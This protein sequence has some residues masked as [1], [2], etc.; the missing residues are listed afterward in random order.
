MPDSSIIRRGLLSKDL[1]SSRF[2]EGFTIIIPAVV[3]KECDVGGGKKEFERLAEFASKGRIKL[4]TIGSIEEIPNT[5]SSAERDERIVSSALEYNA[6]VITADDSMK[7][8][9]ISKGVFTIF[10]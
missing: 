10:I 6:I 2:F 1:E 4:E 9:S 3:R 5:L 7:A 8:Y